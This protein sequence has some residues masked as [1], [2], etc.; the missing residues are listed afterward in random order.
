MPGTEFMYRSCR[1]IAVLRRYGLAVLLSLFCMGS[2]ATPLTILTFLERPLV[3]SEGE[4]PTGLVVQVIEEMMRRS[5]VDYKLS[6]MPPK[7]TLLMAQTED[8]TCVFPIERSQEREASFRWVS[9]VIISRHGLYS[10]PDRRIPL[11]TLDDAKSYKI[12]SF[13]GSGVGEYLESFGY[14]V[15]YA[16]RN[17]LNAGKLEKKRID[18]WASDRVSAEFLSREMRFDVGDPELSFFTTVRAMACH[19]SVDADTIKLLQTILTGMYRDGTI[20]RIYKSYLDVD[21]MRF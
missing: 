4:K 14:Q 5:G 20:E 1:R 13:L 6:L 18:L 10:H 7:R 16:G 21:R 19:H 11:I 17:E 15:E 12:G 2:W 3:D 8:H 9:P